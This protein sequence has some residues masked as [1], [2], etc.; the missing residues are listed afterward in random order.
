M[1]EALVLV[2]AGAFAGGLAI[3]C[4]RARRLVQR[5]RAVALASHELRNGLTAFGLALSRVEGRVPCTADRHGLVAV[6]HG[7]DRLLAVARELEVARGALPARVG[8]RPELVDVREI[9]A[10][11]VDQWNASLPRDSAIAFDWRAGE[12]TLQGY[13]MRLTQAFDNLVAN[14]VEHGRGPVTVRGRSDG[15]CV[16]VLVLD[17]GAG[18]MRPLAEL[19]AR[20]WQAPR[21]HGLVVARRAVELHGGTLRPVRFAS[22]TGIEARLPAGA[23]PIPVGESR[24]PVQPPRSGSG[25]ATR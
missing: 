6:R 21:G 10:R 17:C 18:V 25:M 22:G 3:E 11:V 16:S 5:L 13:P 4:L 1:L 12:S 9:A 20:S 2:A 19:Q 14:A 7:Y 24:G 15:H 23:S 8:P